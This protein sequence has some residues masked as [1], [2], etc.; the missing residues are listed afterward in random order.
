MLRSL[1]R[2]R[3]T[4]SKKLYRL[5]DKAGNNLHQSRKKR[6]KE[7]MVDRYYKFIERTLRLRRWRTAFDKDS[8][9]ASIL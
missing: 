8:F 6:E 7:L 4:T 3:N 5:I 2:Q 1:F 9:P